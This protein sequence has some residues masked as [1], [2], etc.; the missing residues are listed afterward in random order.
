[1][2]VPKNMGCISVLRGS[3]LVAKHNQLSEFQMLQP[4]QSHGL[5]YKANLRKNNSKNIDTHI[6]GN[7]AFNVVNECIMAIM[8][9]TV[10]G[11]HIPVI[12]SVRI[13]LMECV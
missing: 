11:K 3:N 5:Q 1:M 2:R 4:S 7:T 12:G 8:G 13:N 6:E 9:T 10:P